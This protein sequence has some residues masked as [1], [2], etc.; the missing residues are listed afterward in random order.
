DVE[1]P[2]ANLTYA[3]VGT[4][5]HGTA[6]VGAGGTVTYTPAANFNG[7]DSFTYKVTDTGDPAGCATASS[8]CDPTKLSSATKTISLTVNAVNDAPTAAGTSALTAEDTSA[9]VD[10]TTLVS[11]VETAASALTFAVVAQPA[12]G[13]VTAGATRG[14]YVYTPSPN[15]NGPDSF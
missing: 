14:T 5:G 6:S 15:Y 1:T 8:T 2:D 3:V 13:T 11:D 7:L 10:L 9:S 4:P 12:H